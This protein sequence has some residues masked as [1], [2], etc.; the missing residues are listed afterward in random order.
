MT[1]AVRHKAP[2]ATVSTLKEYTVG[3]ES[4]CAQ[5]GEDIRFISCVIQTVMLLHES[6]YAQGH[7]LQGILE[8]LEGMDLKSYPDRAEFREL[9]RTLSEHSKTK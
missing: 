3:A 6:K 1:L 8:T 5:A 7:T 9:I 4:Y 2:D